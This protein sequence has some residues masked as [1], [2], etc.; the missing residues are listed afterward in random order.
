[1]PSPERVKNRGQ[2]KI[3]QPQTATA[4]NLGLSM[5]EVCNANLQFTHGLAIWTRVNKT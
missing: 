5:S 3:V 4:T 2:G 1:M